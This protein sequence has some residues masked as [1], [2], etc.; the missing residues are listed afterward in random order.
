[1]TESAS[2]PASRGPGMPFRPAD[3]TVI[4]TIRCLAADMVQTAGP[5]GRAHGACAG[6]AHALTRFLR[7]NPSNPRWN[8]H[9]C[10]LQY[11]LLHLLGYDIALD[12]LKRYRQLDSKTPGHPESHMTPVVEL[13]AGPLGQGIANAVGLAMAEAHLAATFNRPDAPKIVD[14]YTYVILG[15]GCLQEGVSA[16]AM[17]LAGHW[18]LGKLIELYDDNKIDGT[19][20]LAFTEN[21][22]QRVEAFGWHTLSVPHGDAI[23]QSALVAALAE[24]HRVTDRPTLIKVTTTI[25]FGSS[26]AGTDKVHGSALG[27]DD[28]KRVKQQLGFDPG[29]AFVVSYTVREL[30]AAVRARGQEAEANWQRAFEEYKNKYLFLAA[31]FERR[32]AGRLPDGIREK[33]PTFSTKDAPAATRKWSGQVLGILGD[34]IPD[35]MGGSADLTS[36]NRLPGDGQRARRVRRSHG[37]AAICNGLAAH[38]LVRPFAATFLNFITY[39]YPSVRLAALAHHRVIR[40]RAPADET[41][42]LLRATPNLWVLRPADGNEVVGAYRAAL[43]APSI[44]VALILSRQAVPV[45]SGSSAESTGRG[46]YVLQDVGNPAVALVATGTEVALA[47]EAAALL[48]EFAPRTYHESVLTPGVPVVAVEALGTIGWR[49]YAHAVV[50]MRAFGTSRAPDAVYAKFGITK[51]AVAAK[52]NEVIEY[53]K[54]KAVPNVFDRFE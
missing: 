49:Q 4:N 26:K 16:E 42:A 13:I 5:S 6:R 34:L 29:A 7:A 21:V 32:A 44:P 28:V 38:G 1:M 8:G 30:Y 14:H 48:D 39:A 27:V 52:A 31:D 40:A 50:G 54:G 53:F 17:S 25:G 37:M 15:D 35:L 33:M 46:A 23:D 22:C 12:D 51:E 20:D 41:L 3:A 10:C 36:S 11:I 9:A 2:T 43:N 45:L 18:K 19:T 24:A 47:I